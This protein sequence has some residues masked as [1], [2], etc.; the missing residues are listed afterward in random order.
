MK[1]M[2]RVKADDAQTPDQT[3]QVLKHLQQYLM[4]HPPIAED[5]FTEMLSL[6]RKLANDK[7]LEQAKVNF[8]RFSIY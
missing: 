7:L 2:S 6:A 5:H 8:I 1:Y 3:L 4:A